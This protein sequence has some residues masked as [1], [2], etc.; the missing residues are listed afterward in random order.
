M[1]TES[2][3]L[4]SIGDIDA[5]YES[6]TVE[7]P[8]H[9]MLEVDVPTGMSDDDVIKELD[10][11]D[12]DLVLGLQ[13]IE[14]DKEIDNVEA[15]KEFENSSN[16]GLREGKWHG[17]DSLE[18]GT[19]TIAYGHK[20]TPEESES[21]FIEING[22]LVDLRLGLTQKQA[23]AVLQAD[24]KWAKTHAVASL[25]KTNME[26]DE[27]KVGALTS[28][29]YNVG[30]GAWGGSQAKKYLETGNIEDFMHEA[31][32]EE[33]GFV[34][35]N[36]EK[37]RGLVRR[38]AAEAQL[39]ASANIDE[40]SS[41]GQMIIDTL[42]NLSPIS[43]AMAADADQVTPQ[44]AEQLRAVQQANETLGK[45][46]GLGPAPREPE[47]PAQATLKRNAKDTESVGKLQDM[48][49]MDVGKDRGTFGPATEKAV[50]A[51]QKEQGL[52]ADGV[53][54]KNT[55][56]ALQSDTRPTLV[57]TSYSLSFKDGQT[58]TKKFGSREQVGDP[59]TPAPTPEVFKSMLP[60]PE[61]E[62]EF[63]TESKKS[64]QPIETTNRT[65]SAL[66]DFSK[67]FINDPFSTKSKP[68]YFPNV[69]VGGFT[70]PSSWKVY[71]NHLQGYTGILTEKD[72]LNEEELTG[73]TKIV[74]KGIQAKKT[75]ISYGKGDAKNI[76]Y[77][78][79]D[80]IGYEVPVNLDP[81]I[82]TRLST[83]V[84][85]AEMLINGN[86]I[87][88]ADEYDMPMDSGVL[89]SL[90]W[91][92]KKLRNAS[93]IEKLEYISNAKGL[94][95]K[96]H[97]YGELFLPLEG[98]ALSQRYKVGTIKSLGLSKKDVSHLMTLKEYETWKIKS[99]KMNPSNA[100]VLSG[101]SKP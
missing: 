55:W 32:S 15:I 84:G 27:G 30:S 101:K 48:L 96:A 93:L 36:G 72:T 24:V 22:E 57:D 47:V 52:T 11:I 70:I 53:V 58:I 28:L 71:A 46:S 98:K 83:T 7:H 95:G 75:G 17:H 88:V 41:F 5:T 18:G 97:R 43:S 13:N 91:T 21:G 94:Q 49:G 79:H 4:E 82:A 73:L 44:D 26:D 54:G 62:Q 56:D 69:S 16:V 61:L 38:R 14:T 78:K 37:S 77:G 39:F 33:V 20:L 34:K 89:K 50:K 99:G 23:E 12:L 64:T 40:G 10:G 76:G 74:I 81:S 59:I 31:F 63:S 19:Q 45:L 86:D 3:N 85:K 68:S 1:A 65:L 2:K 80:K 100:M 9:G 29:I 35:V 25:K 51:F 66:N 67:E 90:G 60:S 8:L 92:E 42:S 87:L 6:V